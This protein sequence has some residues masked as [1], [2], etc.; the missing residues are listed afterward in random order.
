MY[1]SHSQ[2]SSL[3][4]YLPIFIDLQEVKVV[5]VIT[6]EEQPK[7]SITSKLN[8]VRMAGYL[9]QSNLRYLQHMADSIVV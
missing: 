8:I 2:Y 5:E 6:P 4:D 3:Q 1:H 7:L 9:H